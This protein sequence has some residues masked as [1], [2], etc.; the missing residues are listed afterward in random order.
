MQYCFVGWGRRLLCSI[1]DYPDRSK[2]PAR[3]RRARR[4]GAA[5]R[6]TSPASFKSPLINGHTS[7]QVY[8]LDLTPLF[9]ALTKTA[10][11]GGILP[12]SERFVPTVQRSDVS[13][14]SQS[15]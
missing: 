9:L 5:S 2:I 11:V 13:A 7:I 10:G 15:F 8:C 6:A 14:G 4:A 12:N 3:G 1:G